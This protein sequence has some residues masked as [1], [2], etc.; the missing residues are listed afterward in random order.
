MQNR[1][2][3]GTCACDDVIRAELT[4]P[5]ASLPLGYLLYGTTFNLLPLFLKIFLM[6]T[7]FKVVIEFVT[8]LLLVLGFGSFAARYV[9][10]QTSTIH[11]L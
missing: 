3:E 5:G 7:I 2:T 1:S 6:W 9:G 11:K 4:N 8:I 10:S